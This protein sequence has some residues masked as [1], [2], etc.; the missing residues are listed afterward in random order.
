MSISARILKQPGN[1]GSSNESHNSKK[2]ES[3]DSLSPV[4]PVGTLHSYS[5]NY[6]SYNQE[7]MALEIFDK[8]RDYGFHKCGKE[9]VC[10]CCG[11]SYAKNQ[12]IKCD[13]RELYLCNGC[14]NGQRKYVRQSKSIHAISI[15]M[16]GKNK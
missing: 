15:P 8:M 14:R 11:E 1:Q 13:T 16:G 10:S 12:G 3:L 9:F 6:S 5:R 7:K 4:S 2:T